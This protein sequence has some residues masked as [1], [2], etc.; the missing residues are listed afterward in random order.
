MIAIIL[1]RVQNIVNG[2]LLFIPATIAILS[3][4]IYTFINWESRKE[5]II[6]WANFLAVFV[7]IFALIEFWN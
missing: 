7:L 1:I 6:A 4:F 5:L 2:Y 3:L